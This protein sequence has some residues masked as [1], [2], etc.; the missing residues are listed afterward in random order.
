M[1]NRANTE[2]IDAAIDHFEESWSAD[3]LESIPEILAEHNLSGDTEAL[4]ELIRIDIELRY[5][6]GIAMGLDKYLSQFTGLLEQPKYLGQIA[7]E[8]YRTRKSYGHTVST[9][10]WNHLPGIKDAT[11]FQHLQIESTLA[12]AKSRLAEL[13]SDAGPDTAFEIALDDAGFRLVQQIGEGAMGQVYLATQN[14]LSNRFVVLKIVSEPLAEPQNMALMQHTN[15]VPIYS[16]HE[17]L[18]RSVICMPYAGR[19]TLKDILDDRTN[20]SHGAGQSL[21]TTVQ[22][23]VS[24]TRRA[25]GFQFD[26]DSRR[27]AVMIP[28]ADE[29]AVLGPLEGLRSL[30]RDQLATWM[31]SRMASGL[32]H[33]HARGILHNDLKPG[34]VL[35]R[36]DGEPALLD[37]NLSMAL[38]DHKAKYI[39]GTLPY[40]SPES[41]QG[42]MREPS[43]PRAQSD[44]YSM[45]VMLFQF[46][47]GRLPYPTPNSMAD[48]DIESS[49]A[50]RRGLPTW[51]DTDNVSQG[52]R[53]IIE[54][55]LAYEPGDRYPSAEQLHQDLL[56]E[57]QCLGL[58]HA[59]E[60]G[61]NRAKKFVRR[62]P[63]LTSA[64]T[65]GMLLLSIVA[66]L[67]FTILMGKRERQHLAAINAFETFSKQSS[68]T[69]AALAAEPTR[70]NAAQIDAGVELLN[71]FGIL[72]GQGIQELVSPRMSDDQ[73]RKVTEAVRLHLLQLAFLEA[74]HLRLES[75]RHAGNPVNP[76][77]LEQLIGAVDRIG[78]A[79][80]SRATV[81][82]KANMAELSGKKQV[83][84]ELIAGAKEIPAVGD[85]ELYMEALRLHTRYQY[86]EAIELLSKLSDQATVP[87]TLRW[88]SLGRSQF[89]NNLPELAKIS[90]SQSIQDAPDLAVLYT[91]RG[92]CHM[93]L[94]EGVRAREDF[95]KAIELDP[96]D[97][98]ALIN[99]GSLAL[100]NR[101]YENA[102]KDFSRVLQFMPENV[103]ALLFRARA[104][105]K[106]G[107]NELAETDFEH[108]MRV[109]NL[110]VYSLQVRSQAREE[111]DP[112]GAVDDIRRALEIEP[113]NPV[114]LI[115]M[116][117]L[118]SRKLNDET[119]AIDFYTKAHRIRPDIDLPLADRAVL[120]ARA[121]EYDDARRD[122]EE[123][124]RLA[125]TSRTNYQAACVYALM[126]D[127]Q[128]RIEALRQLALAIRSGYD[129][130]KLA[131][132]PDL[133]AIRSM[134]G[135]QAISRMYQLSRIAVRRKA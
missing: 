18:S 134:P 5:K 88:T 6:H 70:Q 72:S 38:G 112:E 93:R 115:R 75:S 71:H 42:L 3:S 19:V 94:H 111:S 122:I 106:T 23:R 36:N 125:R 83:S 61:V 11:W 100:G 118:L 78:D 8:D 54:K 24:E 103:N 7:Y 32:A 89:K 98:L 95:S 97:R 17:I 68:Q 31:F 110:D 127:N 126:P 57:D 80:P 50:Q 34:N 86:T 44:I 2:P 119:K 58:Q 40:M 66:L 131:S 129:T 4:S 73:R 116:G 107:E 25:D 65:V 29:S 104:Y 1:I 99:R 12:K 82:L 26:E 85:T 33:A 22:A 41:Y 9:S 16:I 48:I 102:I 105:E 43:P 79:Q 55:C 52:L 113:D 69:L 60:P 30:N 27:L 77:H 87:T 117:F 53:S 64:T 132:D 15:I 90:F 35:I 76:D 49:I 13:E 124:L 109:R 135:F 128:S 120:R 47:T 133:E 14:E 108:A 91:M 59:P 51:S 74:E 56:Q 121:G 101:A 63:A 114:L 46:V 67:A 123:A 39:G 84:R 130:K 92:L 45:G 81:F 96:R 28:A 62:H 10:R 37:F 21:V 20:D